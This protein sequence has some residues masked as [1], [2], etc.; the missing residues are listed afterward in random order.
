MVKEVMALS[1]LLPY[2]AAWLN[3]SL[4]GSK[5]LFGKTLRGTCR[6]QS[7]ERFM[8]DVGFHA[9]MIEV[10]KSM[11]TKQYGKLT[12]YCILLYS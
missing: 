7:L 9:Q 10:F 6:L 5:T 8:V 4:A 12:M 2:I 3:I 11:N 1:D